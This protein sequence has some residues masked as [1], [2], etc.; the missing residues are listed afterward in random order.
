MFEHYGLCYLF[1]FWLYCTCQLVPWI[2]WMSICYLCGFHNVVVQGKLLQKKSCFNQWQ[3]EWVLQKVILGTSTGSRVS[4]A[5]HGDHGLP[6]C[7]IVCPGIRDISVLPSLQIDVTTWQVHHLTFK[8]GFATA[9]LPLGRSC[10]GAAFPTTRHRPSLYTIRPN[11]LAID[12]RI[13][14]RLHLILAITTHCNY[15]QAEHL[16]AC[17]QYSMLACSHAKPQRRPTTLFSV[18]SSRLFRFIYTPH[19]MYQTFVHL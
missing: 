1:W 17:T 13:L 12:D 5:E 15:V 4:T 19:F 8:A 11:V 2:L 6:T 7:G 18:L 16:C 3:I 10:L 9:L 14:K